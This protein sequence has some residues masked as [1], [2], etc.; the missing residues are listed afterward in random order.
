MPSRDL[1]PHRLR[2]RSCS[3]EQRARVDKLQPGKSSR[4]TEVTW[5]RCKKTGQKWLYLKLKTQ[6][7]FKC[8]KTWVKKQKTKSKLQVWWTDIFGVKNYTL[9]VLLMEKKK[10]C[11][12]PSGGQSWYCGWLSVCTSVRD[13]TPVDRS[14][15]CGGRG[16]RPVASAAFR[17]P[18]RLWMDGPGFLLLWRD[19]LVQ[20]MHSFIQDSLLCS[21][22]CGSQSCVCSVEDTTGRCVWQRPGCWCCGAASERLFGESRCG[23]SGSEEVQ[24]TTSL[25]RGSSCRPVWIFFS[26][27]SLLPLSP[28]SAFLIPIWFIPSFSSFCLFWFPLFIWLWRSSSLPSLLFL[29]FLS[30]RGL[31]TPNDTCSSLSIH[32]FKP[33]SAPI[34]Q[35]NKEKYSWLDRL[36]QRPL[37]DNYCLTEFDDLN[38]LKLILCYFYMFR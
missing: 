4:V 19:S 14:R 12:L 6:M 3:W 10:R 37:V 22:C 7:R 2:L 34:T 20:E 1:I 26:F 5:A 21:V 32:L 33:P 35:K 18:L 30:S 8:I 16:G 38:I 11:I 15:D 31:S 36:K 17:G 24:A 23:F 29:N 25:S 27:T 9:G 13:F 28:S